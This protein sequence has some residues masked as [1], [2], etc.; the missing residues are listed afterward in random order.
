MMEGPRDKRRSLGC[1]LFTSL[2]RRPSFNPRTFTASIK[3]ARK[4]SAGKAC[5]VIFVAD[6]CEA[7]ERWKRELLCRL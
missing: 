7:D 1:I 2:S 3:I 4:S 6:I 5:S